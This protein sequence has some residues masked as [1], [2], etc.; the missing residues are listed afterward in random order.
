MG[1]AVLDELRIIRW[2]M[3]KDAEKGRNRPESMLLKMLRQEEKPKVSGFRTP[4]E[5]EAK[6]M[7]IIAGE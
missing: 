1:L 4:E 5:F 3:T 7:K 2:L 6:R